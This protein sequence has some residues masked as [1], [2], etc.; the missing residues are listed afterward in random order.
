MKDKIWEYH[1]PTFEFTKELPLSIEI[2][3]W[4]GH[5]FFAYD[6]VANM[7]PKRIVELGTFKGN[8]L[9]AFTQAVKD[10][11]LETELHAIDTWEGDEHAGFYDN[12]VYDLFKKIKNKYYNKQNIIEHKKFFDEAIDDF[13]DNSI[14]ILHIDGL[15][16]YDAV[17]HDFETWLPKLNKDTGII[18]LHDVCEKRD[19]FG[20]YKLWDE[21]KN[22][23]FTIT[24]SEYHGLGVLSINK[25]L[26]KEEK[27]SLEN[28]YNS[29]EKNVLYKNQIKNYLKNLELKEKDNI[30]LNKRIQEKEEDNILL[31]KR[32]KK[33]EENNILLN[34]RIQEIE[35]EMHKKTQKINELDTE[36]EEFRSFKQGKI[37]VFLEKYRSLRKKN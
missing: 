6:L 2:S 29:I 21:L 33:E 8:S 17:K 31:N 20:V 9:F 3:P 35:R 5:S 22:K 25:D 11:R 32:I 19:D 37:W 23:Y 27:S 36:L 24:I 13:K 28:Y 7:K 18:L 26:I 1:N 30:L 14:D 12:K 34:K 15:H 16:T 10:F 4:G